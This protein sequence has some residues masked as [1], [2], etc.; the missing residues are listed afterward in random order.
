MNADRRVC[1]LCGCA[2]AIVAPRGE[3]E[4]PCDR[5]CGECAMLPE[6]P[7]ENRS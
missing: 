5:L 4:R 1:G 3:P 6:P 2:F 7:K